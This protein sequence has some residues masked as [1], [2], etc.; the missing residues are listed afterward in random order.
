MFKYFI[1]ICALICILI[2]DSHSQNYADS[3]YYYQKIGNKEKAALF[4]EDYLYS[5]PDNYQVRLDLAY[6]YKELNQINKAREQFDF[7]SKHSLSENEIRQAKDEIAYI[8]MKTGLTGNESKDSTK[9]ILYTANV[10]SYADSGYYYLNK[11]N[12][13]KAAEFFELH[14]KDNP[15]DNKIRLQLG[16][17]YYDQ[18]KLKQSLQQFNYVARNSSNSQDIDN[19]RS[20][21]L[22]IRDELYFVSPRSV[23]IYFYNF[24][25]TYQENYIANL[26]SHANFLIAKRTFTGF[27]LDLY[28]DTRSS[29]ALIYNDRFVEFGGFLRYHFLKNLFAEFRIGYVHQLDQDTSKINLKPLLVY[30]NRFGNAKVYVS[31]KSSSKTSLFMDLYSAAM[32]DYKY[33]NSFLQAA[34]QQVLRFHTGGYSYIEG[35]LTELAQFDSRRLNYNNYAELGAGLRF[36]PDIVY[37]PLFFIEP[38]YKA[39]YFGDIKNSFQVKAGFL[40]NFRTLL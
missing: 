29:S 1:S 38:T 33:E 28:T 5:S 15:K 16:Y 2:C 30:F 10:K 25:D 21:A 31:G 12:K 3:G 34:L 39:Y 32:Y 7:V 17:T 6:L 19:S 18:K 13:K 23:D 9:N 14:L 37:F 20:A 36:H 24:Y 22:V 8:D 4:F 35:Y 26:V 40:F 11:G 27:Y